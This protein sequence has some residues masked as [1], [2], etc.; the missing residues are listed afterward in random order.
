MEILQNHPSLTCFPHQQQRIDFTILKMF[1][2]FDSA[3]SA[4]KRPNPPSRAPVVLAVTT[5]LYLVSLIFVCAQIFVKTRVG[6]I[7]AEDYLIV[8]ASVRSP[9]RGNEGESETYAD[10]CLDVATGIVGLHCNWYIP[11]SRFND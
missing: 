1:L 7:G 10:W 11:P 2:N 4:T 9:F 5:S 3:S 8:I 6:K